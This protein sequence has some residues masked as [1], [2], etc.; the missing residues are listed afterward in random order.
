MKKTE[1]VLIRHGQTPLNKDGMYFGHLDPSLND[2]G[3]AQLTKTRDKLRGLEKEDYEV[4]YCS[5]LKRCKESLELLEIDKKIPVFYEK[6]LRELYFG[7][8]EGKMYDEIIQIYPELEEQLQINW[9]KVRFGGGENAFE[10]EERVVDCLEE[11]FLKYKGK[12]VLLVAHAGVIKTILSYYLIGNPDL[13]WKFFIENGSISKVIRLDDGY[14]FFEYVN[15]VD[16]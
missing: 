14:T 2:T 12:R 4:I 1:I 6:R 5:D 10:L 8:C 13:H 3:I 16:K 11:I 7:E 9:K 15:V